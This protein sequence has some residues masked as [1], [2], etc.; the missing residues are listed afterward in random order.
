MGMVRIDGSL[1]FGAVPYVREKLRAFEEAEPFQKSLLIIA[2]GINFLDVAGAEF[3]A[4]EAKHRRERGGRLYLYEVKEGVCDP[5][6]K[7]GLADEIGRENLFE[8][9]T[10]AINTIIS[11]LNPEI[12]KT[13]TRR[14]FLE[15][16]E[17]NTVPQ[18][19]L[20]KDSKPADN[21]A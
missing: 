19:I 8:S 20:D 11:D 2:K 4:E 15:C 1:F 14:I 10:L 13:C 12:C 18:L 5:L 7:S 9:K 6:K 17:P 21:A 3:L 16:G